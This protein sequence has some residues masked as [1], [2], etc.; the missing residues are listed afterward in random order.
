M[1]VPYRCSTSGRSGTTRSRS[2]RVWRGGTWPSAVDELLAADERRRALTARVEE[3]R[4]EQN[5]ASKA[6]GGGRRRREAA[7]DRGGRPGSRRAEGA[8]AAA[9]RGRGGAQ[10]AAGADARTCPHE[11]APDG[12]TDED[13]VEIRRNQASRPSFDFEPRDHVGARRAPRACSTSSAARAPAARGSSTCWATS[14]SCSSRWCATRMDI[15]VEKGFTAGDPA[16]ARAR[17]G[18]VRHRVPADRRGATSTRPRGRAVPGRAPPRCRS[19]RCTWARSSTRRDLPL[20]YAGLLHVLPARGRHLR[21]GHGRHV[22]RAPVRQGRD[23]RVHDARGV[24]WDEHEFILSIEEEI[25][26]NLELPVPR[27]EHRGRRPGRPRR[28]EVRHRGL[29]AGAGRATAS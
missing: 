17:G 8:G 11:S 12:F 20:R 9:R 2:A 15:L 1:K 16:G 13:A 28:E 7:A 19:R 23:V 6:I 3:L 4:A 29:A 22:P 21:Q 25:I 5:R 26:G 24:S 18:D 14:C 10:R 27:R